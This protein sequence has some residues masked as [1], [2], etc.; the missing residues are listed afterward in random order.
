MLVTM[1]RSE[2]EALVR[3]AVLRIAEGKRKIHPRDEFIAD[4][5]FDS[6]RIVALS[7]ALEEAFGRPLLLSDW[8]SSGPE[9]T[10]LNVRSLYD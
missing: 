10:R 7:I 5:G 3:D 1:K 9:A 6:I 8:L 2:V 4:L